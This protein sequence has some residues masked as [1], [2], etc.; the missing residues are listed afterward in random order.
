[1]SDVLPS[2]I[3]SGLDATVSRRGSLG[4]PVYYFNETGSTNDVAAT[5]AEQGSPEGTLV[6]A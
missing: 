1:M 5:L 3:A 4:S 2:E 6:L